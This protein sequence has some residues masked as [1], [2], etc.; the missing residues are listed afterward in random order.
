MRVTDTV[1]LW[2]GRRESRT[3]R[4]VFRSFA[5]AFW[6]YV[7]RNYLLRCTNYVRENCQRGETL[8]VSEPTTEYFTMGTCDRRF[9][10]EGAG[11]P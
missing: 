3:W 6:Y 5:E 2:D 7:E 4:V 9:T 8:T 10:V 11:L 1:T